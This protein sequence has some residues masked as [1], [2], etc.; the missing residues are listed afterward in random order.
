MLGLKPKDIAPRIHEASRRKNWKVREALH[1]NAWMIKIKPDTIISGDH[2]REL[3]SLWILVKDFQLDEHAEDAIVWKH[4]VDGIYSA[5]TAYKAQFLGLTLS[6]LDFMVWKAW[7]PPKVKFF[8]WLALQDRIWTA[9]RLER[10]GWENC[11]LCPLCKRVQ[12]SGIHLFVNCRFSIRLW[13]LVTEKFG[14]VHLDTSRWHLEE[15]LMRWWD[16]RTDMRNPNRRAMASLTMLVSWIIWN[17]RN[18]RVFRHKS[19]PPPILLKSVVDEANLWVTA[20][21]KKLGLIVVRE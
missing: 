12:E 13:R 9:D 19:A 1:G 4:A 6:P 3:F 16:A 2:I 15:S 7:A 10:R 8:A 18:T 20:G 5:A 14:L 17:E 11:G 21:A